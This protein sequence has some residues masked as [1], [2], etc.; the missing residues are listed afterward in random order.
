MKKIK[1]FVNYLALISI[2]WQQLMLPAAVWAQTAPEPTPLPDS[3]ETTT[4]EAP[5]ETT[6]APEESESNSPTPTDSTGSVTPTPTVEIIQEAVPDSP[7][8]TIVSTI[9]TG[10]AQSLADNDND[11]HTD[12][13]IVVPTGVGCTADGG[14]VIVPADKEASVSTE[15]EAQSSTGENESSNSDGSVVITTGEAVSGADSQTE[16]NTT[17]ITIEPG[18][19][20]TEAAEASEPISVSP[21]NVIPIIVVENN[22]GAQVDNTTSSQAN[23]GENNASQNNGDATIASGDV[24]AYANVINMLNTNVVG[25]NFKVLLMNNL[26]G[27]TGDVNMNEWWK[28]VLGEGGSETIDINSINGSGNY[29]YIGNINWANLNNQVSVIANS[30]YNVANQNG[31]NGYVFSGN[32]T[33]L[34]NIINLVNTNLV[35]VRF[36]LGVINIDASTLGDLII[37]RKEYFSLAGLIDEDQKLSF[38]NQNVAL[39]DSLTAATATTGGNQSSGNGGEMVTGN[40]TALSNNLVVTSLNGSNSNQMFLSLNSLGN[41]SGKIYNWQEPGSVQDP[42]GQGTNYFLAGGE[43]NYDQGS[44]PNLWINNENGALITNQI[45]VGANTGNNQALDNGGSSNIYCAQARAWANLPNF[46]NLNLWGSNWFYGLVNIIGD[47]KGNLI[48]AYPDMSVK[49][50]SLQQEV[51]IGDNVQYQIRFDNLGYDEAEKVTISMNL[52]GGVEYIEDDS[53]ITPQIGGGGI[54]WTIP[55]VNPKSGGGFKVWVEVTDGFANQI[56]QG[57]RLIPIAWA[58]ESQKELVAEVVIKSQ[59]TESNTGN[60]RATAS[61][62]VMINGEPAVGGQEAYTEAEVSLIEDVEP[63]EG[64]GLDHRQPVLEIAATNNVNDFVF[65]EDVVKFEIK[66]ANLADAPAEDSFLI[67]KTIDQKGN[68]IQTD[69]LYIGKIGPYKK[70]NIFYGIKMRKGIEADTQVNTL[71]QIFGR[72][73]DGTE[74]N[75]NLAETGYLLKFVKGRVA[76][77]KAEAAENEGT[78]LGRFVETAGEPKQNIIPY[79]LLFG[80]SAAWILRRTSDWLAIIKKKDA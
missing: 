43:G 5:A 65:P 41:W 70:G 29:I 78:I 72:A 44:D 23:S 50:A 76:V 64:D 39:I 18:S 32:A 67:H 42:S 68:L 30:G 52:P 73:L 35:G 48:V 27:E 33:A 8:P 55:R 1:R 79:I 54:S 3:Q 57:L 15:T 38:S 26:S 28:E 53:G 11:I 69:R 14:C 62:R 9:D 22:N 21:V 20:E 49:I 36:F 56:S 71:I 77:A 40:A 19:T 12:G 75:S 6:L 25:G 7:T 34:A 13:Q 59:R 74:I 63:Q 45:E 46:V 10:N 17:L 24:V 2:F 31:G 37:P 58:A 16:V 80:V 47:W 60:K 61:T 51:E 66:V 4:T